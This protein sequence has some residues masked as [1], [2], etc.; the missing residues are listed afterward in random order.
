VLFAIL[1]FGLLLAVHF[2]L[3]LYW[4]LVVCAI[5]AVVL[6]IFTGFLG[7]G[8]NA[9]LLA[10][11]QSIINDILGRERGHDVPVALVW[12][13]W[14]ILFNLN[15][16]DPDQPFITTVMLC[17]TLLMDTIAN[18]LRIVFALVFLSSFVFRPLIQEP[19]GRLWYGAINSAKPTFTMLFG[20]I[21]TLV[22]AGQALAK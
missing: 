4:S 22:A 19:V 18:G 16:P 7:M 6:Y 1:A 11:I 5:Q 8:G 12:P 15:N 3:L 17:F 20:A 21:G 14:P 10:F 2:V 13:K 9:S